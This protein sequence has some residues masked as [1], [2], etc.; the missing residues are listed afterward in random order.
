MQEVEGAYP[1]EP[2]DIGA[3]R[4]GTGLNTEIDSPASSALTRRC[5]LLLAACCMLLCGCRTRHGYDPP[6]IEFTRI[7]L[8]D[9]GGPDK[10]DVIQ[11]R[12]VGARSD[13][14][15]VLFARSGVWYV[16]PFADRPFTP[17]QPDSGWRSTTHFGTEYAALLVEPWYTPPS[18]ADA[19][20]GV[21]GGVV[22]LA[23]VKG[24]PVFWQR[25]WFSLLCI[26]AC[27]SALLAFYS[28]RLHRL[29]W[30]L[31][32]RFEERL[33]ERTRLAQELHDTLLQSVISASMQLDVAVDRLPEDLPAKPSL[34]HVLEIMTQVLEE[35][36]SAL[37][38]LRS[39]MAS[40]P[41][42]LGQA[43]SRI[44][45]EIAAPA[46]IGFRVTVEGRLRPLHPLIR[47]EVY[48]I[49]REALISAFRD[50]TLLNVE[51]VVEY[52]ARS[53]RVAV[54]SIG[55]DPTLQALPS[56]DQ[57]RTYS[58]MRERAERIGA[59][60]NVRS[61]PKGGTEVELSVPSKVAFQR[62]PATSLRG[63]LNK[64]YPGQG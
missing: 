50:D 22:A 52:K 23:V 37:Q 48:S 54:R 41:V 39:S 18:S 16:Q 3:L 1:D 19:L 36:R 56:G 31:N 17:I 21:G 8:A 35:G 11:G 9:E 58:T 15:I 42:D 20:P 40:G 62:Q 30:Q 25:W 28:Y 29:T 26:L 2:A 60:L 4:E 55:H 45:H 27:L 13:Q 47:D 14:Q 59:R 7:P 6:Y 64:L 32:L 51:V 53:L 46:G 12:V 43:F 44:Q 10:I 24:E 61:H 5:V 38:R 49:G 57:H 34:T 63:W 33:A